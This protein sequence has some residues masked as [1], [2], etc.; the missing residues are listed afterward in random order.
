MKRAI[1]ILGG[2]LF[3]I[4]VSAQPAGERIRVSD[5][6]SV[7][8]LT[9]NSYQHISV[10]E[11]KGFGRVSSNGVIFVDGGEAILLDTPVTNEQT[12]TLIDWI[13]DSLPAKVVAFV[14]NHWHED[15][16]GG[17]EAVHAKGIR[18][19]AGRE[20]IRIA[21][22][23][24]LPQPQHGFGK[25]K[26]IKVGKSYVVCYYPGPAHARDNIV[27][28]IPSEQVLFAGCMVK[29]AKDKGLGSTADA[30]IGQW[31][32]T[33]ERVVKK[34]PDAEVVVPGH[35]SAG[36]IQLILHT[37]SLCLNHMR[38]KQLAKPGE[39]K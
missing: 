35:G 28:W 8:K 27:V 11:I 36:D 16:M 39:P 3:A 15:C 18:S 22:E 32:A 21:G 12:A 1:A 9:D 37:R 2:C 6:I 19:Y 29:S 26:K 38:E 5:D 24:G 14:P 20:T 17:I 31:P 25:S 30:D 33:L 4:T 13:E 34:F 10:T 7:V 23:N